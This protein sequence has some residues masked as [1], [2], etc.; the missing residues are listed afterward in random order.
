MHIAIASSGQTLD[1]PMDARFGRAAFFLIVDSVTLAF[2]VHPNPAIQHSGG[3]GIAACQYLVGEGAEA[4]VAGQLGPNAMRVLESADVA[5]FQG[6]GGTVRDNVIACNEGKLE[7]LTQSGPA[8]MG[9][10][11]G[12]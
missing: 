11:S 3:A 2:T 1:A 8:H 9:K 5:L 6:I 12:V 10:G 7:A 4:V